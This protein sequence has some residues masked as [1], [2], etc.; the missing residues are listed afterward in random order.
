MSY[1]VHAQTPKNGLG[2]TAL[3][4]GIIGAVFALIPVVGVFLAVPLGVLALIF[5]V[6]GVVRASKGTANNKGPAIAG[7]VLGGVALVASIAMSA[8]VYS[9]AE[10]AYNNTP[11]Q[12]GQPNAPTANHN[13]AV[14]N[15]SKQPTMSVEMRNAVD[16]ARSY[17]DTMP[18]SEKGLVGQLKFDGYP[19]GVATE[20]VAHLNVNWNTEA[21]QSAQSYLDTM[22][23]SKKGIIGQLKFDG[24]T[25]GQAEHAANQVF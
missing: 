1:P 13:P 9:A 12:A 18:F 11:V 10:Q 19:K 24:F 4:L 17:V 5:G 20:A 22:S 15:N 6:V 21:V 16:T 3:V 8:A 2:T 25:H 7:T 23:F 14:Q